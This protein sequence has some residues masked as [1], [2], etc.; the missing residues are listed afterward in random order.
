MTTSQHK[1]TLGV[2]NL[3]QCILY[4]SELQ[5]QISDGLWENA[6]P[7]DHYK[8]A[9][10]AEPYVAETADKL[11]PQGWRP[12]RCYGFNSPQLKEVIGDRMIFAVKLY[13]AFPALLDVSLSRSDSVL[14]VVNMVK[15]GL[16]ETKTKPDGYYAKQSR[17]VMKLLEVDDVEALI[18]KLLKADEVKY[19]AKNLSKDLR[20][21]S[22]IFKNAT[23]WDAKP[24]A[25]LFAT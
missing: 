16:E 15:A 1:Y 19:T 9:C 7:H 2:Q 14:G 20:A 3:A 22:T 25:Q 8:E 4:K 17:L 24:W 13:T 18:I 21:L 23:S 5:G 11:G 12:R 10:Q 6:V